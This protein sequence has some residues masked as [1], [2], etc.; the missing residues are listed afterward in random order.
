MAMIERA[1]AG[2]RIWPPIVPSSPP[3]V[4]RRTRPTP[5]IHLHRTILEVPALDLTMT[6]LSFQRNATGY[7]LTAADARKCV[8]YY[9]TSPEENQHPYA[10]PLLAADLSGLPPAYILSAE[11]DPICD[12]G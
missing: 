3:A 9:L 2:E 5:S 8:Q 6:A 12:D 10:S 4:R 11:Y 1:L 7:G